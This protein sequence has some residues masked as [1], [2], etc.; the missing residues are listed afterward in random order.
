MR[1]MAGAETTGTMVPPN[2]AQRFAAFISYAHADARTAIWLQRRLEG[3]RL[4]PRVSAAPGE[5]RIG[6][7]FRDRAD[8]A[9]ATSLSEA[10]RD[11]LARSDALIVLCSAEACASPWVDAEIRLFRELYPDAPVIAV[12]LRGEPAEAMPAA[13]TE[14][15]REP[16][17][18]DLRPHADGRRLG[19]LKI[20]AAL[21][22]LPLDSLIQ[23]DA[24]RRLR[25]VTAIT[26]VV[27]LAMVAMATM[28]IFAIS[29]RH[30]AEAQRERAE[31]LIEYML[32][33]LRSQLVGVGRIDVQNAVNDRALAFYNQQGD[34]AGL[35]DE[36]LERRARVL[37]AMGQDEL[38]RSNVARAQQLLAVAFASTEALLARSPN[39]PDRIFAH[40]QSEYWHGQVESAQGHRDAFVAAMQRYAAL[41]E[42]LKAVDPDHV[43]AEREVGYAEGNLCNIAVSA[44][45][46]TAADIGA[47]CD[48]A[49]AAQRRVLAALPG[50]RQAMTDVANRLGWRATAF[51]ALG[52]RDAAITNDNEA[53]AL[54]R[55]ILAA[56]PRNRDSQDLV[57]AML[58]GRAE[59][60]AAMGRRA[61]A[62]ADYTE[63][64]ATLT[65]LRQVDPSNARWKRLAE[66]VAAA[67][68]RLRQQGGENP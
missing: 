50:D 35:P 51:W 24:Q 19:L 20:I 16:L 33:D 66:R 27:M 68:S 45:Q 23:R 30:E 60:L 58:Q 31:G 2:E 65:D 42:R 61:A 29:A 55:A 52:Q 39:D 1:G 28:T 36:S 38:G 10:I 17:A 59:H 62:M 57:T 4:P 21:R 13:L 9:A 67:Q 47:H 18:A 11:A 43:R 56:D 41:A 5:R 34:V 15:G 32:T 63:A 37:Q 44:A 25:R 22:A 14:D 8:L 7:I 6:A 54:S 12:V 49:L 48:N 40:A 26:V 3:Y 64:A 46:P 53:L